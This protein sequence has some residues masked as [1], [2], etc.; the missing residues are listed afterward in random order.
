MT[1]NLLTPNPPAVIAPPFTIQT[2][3]QKVRL[4]EDGW[5]SR[6][7]GRVAPCSAPIAPNPH[8]RRGAGRAIFRVPHEV[9]RESGID[10]VAASMAR[11]NGIPQPGRQIEVAGFQPGQCGR[12]IGQ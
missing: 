5:N 3:T 4:A 2:A 7:P 9:V 12:E 1:A 11:E 8:W 6:D 10:T